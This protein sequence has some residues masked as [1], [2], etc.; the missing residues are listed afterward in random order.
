MKMEICVTNIYD[1]EEYVVIQVSNIYS[2]INIVHP[3]RF[4]LILESAI[5]HYN[6]KR[7]EKEF[8]QGYCIFLFYIDGKC[9]N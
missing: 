5:C 3:G 1:M 9:R 7:K 8:F 4:C 6:N 2:S